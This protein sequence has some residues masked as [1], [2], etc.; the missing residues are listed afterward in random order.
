MCQCLSLRRR[1]NITAIEAMKWER[2]T[3]AKPLD[4]PPGEQVDEGARGTQAH[5]RAGRAARGQRETAELLLQQP[6]CRAC[7]NHRAGRRARRPDARQV[8]GHGKELVARV[9][10]LHGPRAGGPLAFVKCAIWA[11]LGS[12]SEL[13]VMKLSN[14][15]GLLAGMGKVEQAANAPPCSSTKSARCAGAQSKLGGYSRAAVSSDWVASSA[16]GEVSIDLNQPLDS[17]VS[18]NIFDRPVLLLNTFT[19]NLPALRQRKTTFLLSII[20]EAI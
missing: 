1:D 4:L 11:I 8:A 6:Q 18:R 3:T 20:R 7:E 15:A 13:F 10:H 17:L 16:R 19:I 12:Q 9:L 14:T 5:E 2:S